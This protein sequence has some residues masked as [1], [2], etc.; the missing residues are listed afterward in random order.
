MKA[1]RILLS[2]G[3]GFI[4]QV[5]A[6]ALLK[7]GHSVRILT[8]QILARQKITGGIFFA[9]DITKP[10]TLIGVCDGIELVI[11]CA[12][13]PGHPIENKRK[14]Y[15]YFEVDGLGTENLAKVAKRAGVKHIIYISG[16][17][18]GEAG[19]DGHKLEPWFKAKW[20]AEQAIYAAGIP[21]TILR[22]SWVYGPGDKTLNRILRAMKLFPIFPLIGSGKNRVQPI[23]VE[24]LA[25]IVAVCVE[26]AGDQNRIFD[27]GGPQEFKMKEML[28]TVLH[29]LGK[30]CF[31]IPIPKPF[32]KFAA[33]FLQF[34][35]NPPLNPN[36]V[37]FVTMDVRIDIAPLKKTFPQIQLKSL[38]EGLKSYLT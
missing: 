20:Y 16:A 12:Q 35:P 7:K 22:P 2:G 6:K 8:R 38:E 10:E 17:G 19:T 30:K 13:F 3:T 1:S 23:F 32:M 11:Q 15:T 9:G 31:L 4:G 33:F 25:Q 27:V 21:R 5:V 29:V 37:D 26:T 36:A 24:D 28:K 34:L 18:T 14:H